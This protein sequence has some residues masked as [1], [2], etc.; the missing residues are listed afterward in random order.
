MAISDNIKIN[1]K[2]KN[3]LN[4]KMPNNQKTTKAKIQTVENNCPVCI[5]TMVSPC[6]LPCGHIF[7]YECLETILDIKPRCP[8][9]R[10]DIKVDDYKLQ[11]DKS[12]YKILQNQNKDSMVEREK[13]LIAEMKKNSH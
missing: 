6:K 11:V 4:T 10:Q 13:E 2:L 3:T 1:Y 9:C 5:D 7:C 8:M 12:L